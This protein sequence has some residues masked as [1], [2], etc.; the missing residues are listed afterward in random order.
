MVK[1][2]KIKLPSCEISYH[3]ICFLY[4]FILTFRILYSLTMSAALAKIG[5]IGTGNMSSAIIKGLISH[6]FKPSNLNVHD[7]SRPQLTSLVSRLS[8]VPRSSNVDVVTS[9]DAVIVGVKPYDFPS[10]LNEIKSAAGVRKPVISIAGGLTLGTIESQ[11]ERGARVVRT[12]PNVC[13]A[14]SASV[15]GLAGGAFAT[16]ADVAIARE[17]FD[18]VGLTLEIKESLFDAFTAVAGCA[19]AFV[20]PV[21]E[22]LADGGVLVGIARETAIR[23]AAQ[24]MLG[25]AKLVLESGQHPAELKDSVCS[26]GGSTIV[27]V[28]VIEEHAVRAAFINAVI[29]SCE[30]GKQIGEAAKKA[31]GH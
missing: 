14:V 24:M 1:R 12:I 13:A 18:A 19:L 15:T 16:P 22:A 27:G 31:T 28:K 26:P 6:G 3:F 20:F 8:V 23:L 21:I 30:K 25:S 9:S 4:P 29:A 2:N 7:I 10:V 17:I 11:L 5:F